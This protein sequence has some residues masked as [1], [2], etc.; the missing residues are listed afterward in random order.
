MC[1]IHPAWEAVIRAL[2]E[3][4]R[5]TS[6]AELAEI[7]ARLASGAYPIPETSTAVDQGATIG[8]PRPA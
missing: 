3:S 2:E 1:A 7:D 8:R 5:T 4:L 6:S